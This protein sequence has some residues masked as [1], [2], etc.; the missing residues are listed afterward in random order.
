MYLVCDID[1]P[2]VPDGMRDRG[3][4]RE[5]MHELFLSELRD[6]GTP[7]ELVRGD[8]ATRLARASALVDQVR[9]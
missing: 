4:R 5:E 9:R 7:W 1:L 3:D 6:S 2:W 8:Q